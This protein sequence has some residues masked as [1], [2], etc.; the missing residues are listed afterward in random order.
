[1]NKNFRLNW[2]PD[3][4]SSILSGWLIKVSG[5]VESGFSVDN[6]IYRIHALTAQSLKGVC[7]SLVNTFTFYLLTRPWIGIGVSWDSG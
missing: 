3:K 5:S 1:M 6:F 7:D 2:T 4:I